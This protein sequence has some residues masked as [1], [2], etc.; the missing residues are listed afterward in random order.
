M[1][2]ESKIKLNEE[3]S[4][5]NNVIKVTEMIADKSLSLLPRLNLESSERLRFF[6]QTQFDINVNDLIP[7]TDVLHIDL[8]AYWFDDEADY[9]RHRLTLN[10]NCLSDF[11]T[12][13]I[14]LRLVCVN[15]K[16][17]DEFYSS[18][19]HEVNHIYQ[20]AN[21]ASK[22]KTLY[23]KVVKIANNERNPREDRFV[24]NALYLTFTTEQDSFTNQY[25]AYLKQNKVP[26]DNIFC[27][28]P[29]DDGNPYNKFL[30]IY[31]LIDWNNLSDKHLFK[32]FGINK[33]QLRLRLY[34]ADKR[35]RNKLMK[36]AMRYEKY[37]QNELQKHS[38]EILVFHDMK[39][40]N[41]LMECIRRGIQYDSSEFEY[42]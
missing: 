39:R 12:Q 18:I 25:F 10:T 20:Y 17:N 4:V 16:P 7:N 40:V 38:D 28:F 21:G 23:D 33:K 31:E 26:Y 6:K 3:L 2:F 14:G 34:N 9:E 36:A 32:L 19:Q 29:E 42:L 30:D 13:S 5:A 41:F 24:A 1:L 35:I 22:N 8:F 27:D 15:G 37:L 11:E